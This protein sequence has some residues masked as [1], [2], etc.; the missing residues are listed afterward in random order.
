MEEVGIHIVANPRFPQI[1][2]WY[3]VTET[4]RRR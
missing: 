1:A 2:N 4:T 3:T